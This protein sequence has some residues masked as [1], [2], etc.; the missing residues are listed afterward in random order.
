METQWVHGSSLNGLSCKFVY[1]TK[2]G[3]RKQNAQ[4]LIDYSLLLGNSW[5]HWSY[6]KLYV[7]CNN[8]IR[9]PADDACGRNGTERWFATI[10]LI[11]STWVSIIIYM[12]LNINIPPHPP[13]HSPGQLMPSNT[14]SM[15]LRFSQQVALGMQYLSAKGFVHR[16]MAARNVL[17]TTN[18]ICKV[19]Y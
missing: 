15:L 18:N 8:A 14:F 5:L 13:P 10:S 2:L 7:Q 12:Q 19:V 16:D 17:V 1:P 3:H 11:S 6:Y 9:M 4:S